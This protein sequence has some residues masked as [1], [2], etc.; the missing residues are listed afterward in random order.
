[1]STRF[2]SAA[3][4]AFPVA[5][6]VVLTLAAALAVVAALLVPAAPAGAQQHSSYVR[7]RSTLVGIA[8]PCISATQ[9]GRGQALEAD[10]QTQSTTPNWCIG[11]HPN[12]NVN[13]ATYGPLEQLWK[14]APVSLDTVRAYVSASNADGRLRA[15]TGLIVETRSRASSAPGFND[16]YTAD[17]YAQWNDV[18][19]LGVAPV[20]GW[21]PGTKV[22]F[23]F[24][25][26][27]LMGVVGNRILT[28]ASVEHDVRSRLR[29]NFDIGVNDGSSHDATGTI[30]LRTD[31]TAGKRVQERSIDSLIVMEREIGQFERYLGFQYSLQTD[32]SVPPGGGYDA[33]QQVLSARSWGFFG[34][35]AGL[36]GV[37]I[38]D[39]ND[40]DIT[41]ATPYAFVNGT[42]FVTPTSTVPEPGTWALL[43]TGLLGL[44]GVARR[45]TAREAR[46]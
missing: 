41:A 26:H 29:W 38:L 9:T 10:C 23:S 40:E 17:A 30:E 35:T 1:M 16:G 8:Q 18:L 7:A 44:A 13:C 21:A 45:R 20:G 39:A 31:G 36:T 27:G 22:Q 3:P 46:R 19:D 28:P 34:N 14:E 5:R 32:L 4:A 25:V 12:S 6:R 33:M 2:R 11:E 37:R 42:Q 15:E 43:G 24:W